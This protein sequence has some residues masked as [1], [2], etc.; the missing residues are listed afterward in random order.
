MPNAHM[1]TSQFNGNIGI[2][3][4]GINGTKDI[5]GESS[6]TLNE[7]MS[8]KA[9][10]SDYDYQNLTSLHNCSGCLKKKKLINVNTTA[11]SN[12]TT[13]P[14]EL[15][16]GTLMIPKAVDM[17][18]NLANQSSLSQ[19]HNKTNRMSDMQKKINS[20]NNNDN[21]NNNNN[22]INNNNKTNNNNINN[23]N[24]NNNN[25]NNNINN[26]NNN[27]NINNN[28]LPTPV[29]L[30]PL[31]N[32]ANKTQLNSGH[33]NSTTN[34]NTNLSEISRLRNVLMSTDGV[35]RTNFLVQNISRPESTTKQSHVGIKAPNVT[36]SRENPNAKPAVLPTDQN[37]TK[38]AINNSQQNR[39]YTRE[40][41]E[42]TSSMEQSVNDV[43]RR[44]EEINTRRRSDLTGEAK[45]N[46]K[47]TILKHEYLHILN[48]YLET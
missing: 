25:I 44:C 13:P 32:Q 37:S 21:N 36:N 3:S 33:K 27:Y 28:N 26:N 48:V 40:N 9:G 5:G 22:N 29:P 34:K 30:K 23:N 45:R 42:T 15:K 20:I 1:S 35:N 16:E 19:Q 46:M 39:T 47:G 12:K 6:R 24:N 4:G 17:W 7:T 18:D 2:K 8:F 31:R 41:I 11:P 43:Q 38:L 14:S 10:R